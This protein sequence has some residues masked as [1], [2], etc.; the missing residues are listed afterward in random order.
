MRRIQSRTNSTGNDG[1]LH[2]RRL[3]I[4][5]A[6]L[7]LSA[8]AAMAGRGRPER[9]YNFGAALGGGAPRMSYRGKRIVPYRTDEK[10]G[11][12]IIV[13]RERALYHVLPGGRAVRYGV[14]V[15]RQG[16]QWSGVAT[17]RR[18]AMWPEWRPPAEMIAREWKMYRR[19]LPEVMKGGPGNPLGARAL[20]LYQG[21][22]DTLYR[23]H[24]TNAPTTIGRAVSS[25][26]IRM[27][28]EEI[29]ELYD[30]VPI[31]TRVVVI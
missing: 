17:I 22:R 23:I 29:I 11:T 14:G 5:A 16:F 15:G 6:A 21:N 25:G 13:T 18:K 12:I 3:L 30:K 1:R 28:N 19:R 24:G 26:C 10:P 4:G 2:R 7:A 31:G 27:L 8:P 20:Y 9:R